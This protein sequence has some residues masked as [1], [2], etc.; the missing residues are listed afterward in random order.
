[1]KNTRLSENDRYKIEALR[2]ARV[3]VRDIADILKK[4]VSC[5]YYEL[6]K[7]K[8][9]QRDS[10]YR[11]FMIYKADAGQRITDE[12]KVKRGSHSK[13]YEN[14]RIL[15]LL[16]ELIGKKKL[17]PWAASFIL[18]RDYDIKLS[19]TTIY[20]WIYD[21][22]VP[23]LSRKDLAYDKKPKKKGVK[24]SVCVRNACRP[25]VSD[26]DPEV[27]DR[28]TV[29][30]WEMDTV[31]SGKGSSPATL[32]VL[33]ERASRKEQLFKI[34]DRSALSVVRIINR[35]ER[36][37]GK[38]SFRSIYKTITVDNGVEFAD[39]DSIVKGDR[40]L[41]FYCHPYSSFERGSNENQNKL[42]R[43]FIPKG[44]DIGLYSDQE[45]K[46]IE[47]WINDLPRKLFNG[48]SSNEVYSQL[49]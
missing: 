24:R 25:S 5:I 18:N 32:L 36:K 12:R 7:G 44:D 43:R 45:I 2:A 6:R 31:Y 19:K 40:T 42:I 33:T 22:L 26:R 30:H 20:R 15:Q 4:S 14:A 35:L 8:V 29:G 41:L 38:K 48:L 28:K 37:L 16:H 10:E 34:P 27:S 46:E 13:L 11:D 21:G 23:D 47:N 39:Y 49:A 17:S 9:M 1:M 3:P